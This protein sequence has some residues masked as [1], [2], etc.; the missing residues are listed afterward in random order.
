MFMRA[1]EAFPRRAEALHGA[2]RYCRATGKPHQG[3]L[4]ARQ[5]LDIP[6]PGTALFGEPWIY[7]YG[8]LDEFAVNAYWAGHNQESLDAC[9]RL[10]REGR[11]S[12][13]MRERIEANAGF[14]REKLTG[15]EPPPTPPKPEL[16]RV[17][18]A[19]LAK[20]KE[21]VLPFYLQCIEAL[22]YPK[23]RIVLYVRTNNS[24]DRTAEIMRDW[25]SRVGHLYEQVEFDDAPVSEDVEQ[26]GVHEWNAIRFKVLG[27]I[28]Q[29]SLDRAWQSGCD[30]YFVAD[31]DNFIRP[32]TLRALVSANLPV[33]S[34]LL[35]HQ[36][37]LKFYSNYHEKVDE[38]GYFANSEEYF[39]ILYQRVKGWCEVAVVHCTYLVRRDAMPQLHYVDATERHE[40]VIFSESARQK[41]IPQYIDTRDI[42]GYLT[43]DEDPAPAI[44]LIGAEIR[45]ALAVMP[46]DIPARW[47]GAGIPTPEI[48]VRGNR[49]D[50]PLARIVQ[51]AYDD[52]LAGRGKLSAELL[53]FHGASGR[54][55]RLFANNLIGRLTDA[56]Y[57]EI[58]SSTGSTLC[59]TIAENPV[60]ALVIDNWSQFG[61]PVCDFMRNVAGVRGAGAR[62]SILEEDFRAVDYASIGKY[63][64][65]MFDGPHTEQDHYDAVTLAL[66]ALDEQFVLIVDDWDWSQVR[67]GTW[68]AIVENGLNVDLVIDIRTT[69]DGTTPAVGWEQSDWHNGYVLAVISGNTGAIAIP[70]HDPNFLVCCGLHGSGSTW[71]FNVMREIARVTGREFTSIYADIGADV[72]PYLQQSQLIIAKSHT[73]APDFFFADETIA[74]LQKAVV[75]TV[76]DPRDAVASLMT[77]FGYGF[78]EAL[79]AVSESARALLGAKADAGLILRYEDGFIDDRRTIDTIAGLAGVSLTADQRDAILS[80]LSADSVKATID[81]LQRDGCL[82]D[83]KTTWDD[84]TLWHANHVG[85][86]RIGKFAECLTPAEQALVAERTSEFN[87]AFGYRCE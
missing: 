64:V 3:Y 42:Y 20:Q 43:L 18:V 84:A 74:A 58:G 41:Q 46:P 27:R 77:R 44:A 76:R 24:T 15:V 55:Y 31:V 47:Q 26:F 11:I 59:A 68:K 83:P 66:P 50:S 10:L 75:L 67:R 78:D 51:S 53:G 80:G 38:N 70:K 54:K 13:D 17:L 48:A 28:R 22:D 32:H 62:I 86:G 60:K 12:E 35:R 45:D 1:Y 61:G 56:R 71:L 39:W 16:P 25:L 49:Q 81:R 23:N 72:S 87:D 30:F 85:D 57:L 8:L 37:L 19:I 9:E 5:G 21:P 14:A 33:V 82:G 2:A 63:N 69:L 65:Y 7:D 52:A 4:L 34:P 6:Q 29:H 40:Y 79:A 36:D 73:P